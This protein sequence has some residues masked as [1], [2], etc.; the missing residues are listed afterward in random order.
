MAI[1]HLH[2]QAI[3]RSN[4]K[5]AVAS[6]AY[7]ATENLTDRTT[8]EV[9]D[10]RKKERAITSG[11]IAPEN[12]PVWCT[13]RQE[14]WNR[15]E[16]KENRKNSIFCKEINV[17]I[18]NE[19]KSEA[20]NLIEKYIRENFTAKNLVTDYAIHEPNKK[21]DERNIHAHIM[22]TTRAVNA[23]GWTEKFRPRVEI[24]GK[25][26]NGERD[27]LN[28]LRKSWEVVCNNELKRAGS[29][30][31]IDCR[32]LEEQGID[33][34]PQQ[35]QGVTATAMQRKHDD[36]PV[37]FPEPNRTRYQSTSTPQ[38]TMQEIEEA[39]KD[40]EEYLT[41]KTVVQLADIEPHKWASAEPQVERLEKQAKSEAMIETM[42]NNKD[43]LKKEYITA[44]DNAKTDAGRNRQAEP[45]TIEKPSFS[46]A[47]TFTDSEGNRCYNYEDYVERQ[48]CLR[49]D[50]QRKQNEL[51]K[52][53][54]QERADCDKLKT[55]FETDD[56]KAW[57]DV[58]NATAYRKKTLWQKLT[59]IATDFY[60]KAKQ[61]A[62][63][64]ALRGAV[65]L[66]K[67]AKDEEL[68]QQIKIERAM[69]KPTER[70]RDNDNY[71]ER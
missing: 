37:K 54:E 41:A 14:L 29:E 33:R 45:K 44:R 6:S 32:T 52:K 24:D 69:R 13:D 66:L 71:F 49:S 34:E 9:F 28:E 22:V 58:G 38:P 59:N 39:L 48:R 67:E 55:A 64:R 43:V 35:H 7:R 46:F 1:Y 50:W 19:L 68:Q 53:L 20:K 4:G 63:I 47:Y 26:C 18:P 2:M 25:D 21:G 51:D 11:I 10:Y 36:K 27:F 12:A 23:E 61:F 60:Q 42:R 31:R 5:S 3:G 16:E 30:Q 62:P 56:L 17:A 8:G 65:N 57:S 40:N 15:V 70:T